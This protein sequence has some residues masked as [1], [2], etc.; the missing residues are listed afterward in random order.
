MI[1][2]VFFCYSFSTNQWTSKTLSKKSFGGEGAHSFEICIISNIL[3]TIVQAIFVSFIWNQYVKVV[4]TLASSSLIFFSSP[5]WSRFKFS[6]ISVVIA[7]LYSSLSF[8]LS[9]VFKECKTWWKPD[10]IWAINWSVLCAFCF[11]SLNLLAWCIVGGIK[12]CVLRVCTARWHLNYLFI[13]FF[14]RLKL[15]ALL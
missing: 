12:L 14:S 8:L 15:I 3:I 13:S 2:A 10:H 1:Y 11:I 7:I 4:F 6:I 9:Y 5:R